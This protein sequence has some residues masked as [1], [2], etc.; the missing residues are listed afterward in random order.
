M[1]PLGQLNPEAAHVVA[2]LVGIG[3]VCLYALLVMLVRKR[4][5]RPLS[6]LPPRDR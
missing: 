5:G 6:G 1:S 2:A 4:Q 3:L